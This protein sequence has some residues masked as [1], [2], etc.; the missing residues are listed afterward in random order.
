MNK[1]FVITFGFLASSLLFSCHSRKKV[2]LHSYQKYV[3]DSFYYEYN[4]NNGFNFPTRISDTISIVYYPLEHKLEKFRRT[5]N[6]FNHIDEIVL[7]N[8]PNYDF[9]GV[10]NNELIF[11]SKQ[12]E[13]W[14][15]NLNSFESNRKYTHSLF[16]SNDF[17]VYSSKSAGCI[18]FLINDTLYS[19]IGFDWL[20]SMEKLRELTTSNI[21][22]KLIL[23]D[24]SIQLAE[25]FFSRDP[26][27]LKL[28]DLYPRVNFNSNQ[29]RIVVLYS[30]FNEIHFYDLLTGIQSKKILDNK[31]FQT[32]EIFDTTFS[33]INRE[34]SIKR[35]VN[36]F[37][38]K[39]IYYNQSTNH[40]LIVFNLPAEDEKS[41]LNSPPIGLILDANF[42]TLDYIEFVTDYTIT[43]G[44]KFS[45]HPNGV[46]MR[47]NHNENNKD[48]YEKFYLLNF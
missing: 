27:V 14:G 6:T 8:Y 28:Q 38:Y 23:T 18:P 16:K 34:E 47:V 1:L 20:P 33:K 30:D 24:S 10:F 48:Q 5:G 11:Q 26:N 12:K 37:E 32:P 31:L 44:S 29:N 3:V 22:Q 2:K 45:L 36:N 43:K 19:P 13:F 7:E 17:F 40:Y 21:I 46:L 25:S 4:S 42:K 39:N 9:L 41:W 15:L 35:M